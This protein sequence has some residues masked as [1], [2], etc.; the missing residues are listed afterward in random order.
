ML[1]KQAIEPNTLKL[2]KN[3]MSDSQL[4]QLRL[5]GGTALALQFGHRLSVDLDL[6][7]HIECEE[8]QLYKTLSSKGQLK[9][10][11]QSPK[12]KLFL[13]DGIKVDIVE[14]DYPWISDVLNVENIRLAQLEDIAAMKINAIVGRGTRKDFVDL[15]YLLEHFSLEQIMT[16]FAQKYPEYDIFTVIRSLSYFDDAESAP[17]P[18]MIRQESW[19]T[20]KSRIIECVNLYFNKLL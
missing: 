8:Q 12:I 14:Y 9:I 2:L 4:S 16:F 11:S 20:M 13:I 18:K 15:F 6:F 1:S 3:L 19:Q 10:L 17:M 7:G 5:V